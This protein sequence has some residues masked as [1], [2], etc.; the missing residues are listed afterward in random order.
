MSRFIPAIDMV[1]A[2]RLRT[3]VIR[4]LTA[5]VDKVDVL[6]GPSF[7]GGMLTATNFTGQPSL[8]LRAGFIEIN[9]PRPLGP[10]EEKRLAAAPMGERRRVPVGVTL[11]GRLFDEASLF[12]VGRA[13]EAE[14]GVWRERPT[15]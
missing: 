5:W 6:L 2:E 15:L 3:K 14:L 13:L 1:Q 8:T 11:W 12:T 10:T 4:E 9:K 7:A